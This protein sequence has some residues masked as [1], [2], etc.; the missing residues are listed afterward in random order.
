MAKQFN[1]KTMSAGIRR[2]DQSAMSDLYSALQRFRYLIFEEVGP[3]YVDDILH[4]VYRKTVI[5]IRAQKIREEDRLM[6]FIA[7]IVQREIYRAIGRVML[8]RSSHANEVAVLH[9]H[10]VTEDYLVEESYLRREQL[11]LVHFA[12]T[13][14]RAKDSEIVSRFYFQGQDKFQI[15]REMHMTS[16]QFRLVKSRAV[17][18]L[19]LLGRGASLV[20]GSLRAHCRQ[21]SLAAMAG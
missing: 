6:G 9:V 18:K 11:G 17:A 5:A 14:M 2:N 8:E 16:N 12:L 3:A 4:D 21:L 10:G 15:M 1:Y 19:S 7:T 20:K 13:Q